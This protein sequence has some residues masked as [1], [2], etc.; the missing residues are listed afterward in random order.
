MKRALLIIA[1][2]Q[3]S[4]L[5]QQVAPPPPAAPREVSVPQPVERTLANG[6]RVIVVQKSGVPLVAARLMIR[7]GGEA[8]PAGSGG[9]ADMTA[10]LL[11]KGTSTKSAEQIARGVE[12]LGATMENSAEWDNSAVNLS[13]LSSNFAQ[14][15]TYVADVVRNPTFKT[16]EIERLRDQNIDALRVALQ[17]PSNLAGFVATSAIF[18]TAPYGHNLGG[19]PESL[20]KITRADIVAFHQRF[21]RPD[22]AVLVITGDLKPE[23]AFGLAEALFGTWKRPDAPLPSASSST[24]EVPAP[25]AIVVDMPDAGQAAVV[26]A[27][28]GLRR[29]DPAYTAAI[30]ANAILGTGYSSRLNLEIRIKRGLSYGAGSA[31]E[32]RRDVGPFTASAQTKNESA[33]EV[34]GLIIDELN[35]LVATPVDAAELGPRKAVLIGGFGRSLETAAGLANRISTLA[36]YG[37][38]LDEINHFISGVQ[39]VSAEDVQK[40]ASAHL[41]GNQATVVIVGDAQKFL[42]ALQ[43]RF[44][45]VDV[46]PVA[47]LDLN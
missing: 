26:V 13:A 27:R 39:S 42:P 3:W 2:L 15:M 32:L 25:R 33:A 47:E 7:S 10:S 16:D 12:A 31:F 43:Q 38:N 36:L 9:L 20:Q 35:R 14:A 19:T 1:L 29:V 8:D 11:T 22:N 6:L 41:A 34:A 30:V 21:Y 17:D 18:G 23:T 24:A 44:K 46:I 40:F 45:N 4:A 28:Q 5:A 37:L